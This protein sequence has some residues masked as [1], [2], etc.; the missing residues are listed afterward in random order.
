MDDEYFDI[1]TMSDHIELNWKCY[2]CGLQKIMNKEEIL[3]HI[4]L[5]EE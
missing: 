3:N 2:K 5:H 1:Y 4:K